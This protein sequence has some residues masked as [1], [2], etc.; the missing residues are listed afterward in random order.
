[1]GVNPLHAHTSL[2]TMENTELREVALLGQSHTTHFSGWWGREKSEVPLSFR[3]LRA[4][5]YLTHNHSVSTFVSDM[6]TPK[7]CRMTG[8]Q[9]LAKDFG[10]QE[11]PAKE[12]EEDKGRK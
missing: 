6:R 1:M 10:E 9:G 7:I 4:H 2:E 8:S 3:G 12:P 11:V 5:L